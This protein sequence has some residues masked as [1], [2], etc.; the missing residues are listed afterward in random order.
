MEKQMT[1]IK[2]VCINPTE[3]NKD[4][5]QVVLDYGREGWV[6]L[7]TTR[8]DHDEVWLVIAQGEPI[9]PTPANLRTID[10]AI[11]RLRHGIQENRVVA[12]NTGQLVYLD[13]YVA[14]NVTIPQV[15][16][17][18]FTRFNTGDLVCL[19]D[20]YLEGFCH[21]V[22]TEDN[23]TVLATQKLEVTDDDFEKLQ[24]LADDVGGLYTLAS[25]DILQVV[26]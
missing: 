2:E 21:V 25:G 6:A 9:D 24:E 5:L 23:I 14:E 12:L 10:D 17:F 22:Y 4:I 26:V 15:T 16:F 13:T 11:L 8:L 7:S 1:K 20:L 19:Q 18:D 3:L